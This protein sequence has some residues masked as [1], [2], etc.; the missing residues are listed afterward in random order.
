MSHLSAVLQFP[1]P[2]PRQS[3]IWLAEKLAYYADAWDVAQDLANGVAEIVVIDTRSPQHYRA[4]HICAAISFPHRTMN[5]DSLA[6][7]DRDKVYVTYCDGIGC[8]GS[9]RGAW[10]LAAAGFKVKELIGGLDFWRRDQHPVMTGDESGSWP[11]VTTLPD[12]GC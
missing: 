10:K 6:A 8:N 9:T 4:G 12:C 7:L 5:A 2:S 3:E 11:D 1:P